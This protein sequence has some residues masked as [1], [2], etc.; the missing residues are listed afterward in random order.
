MGRVAANRAIVDPCRFN[1]NHHLDAQA[2][3]NYNQ[4][5]MKIHTALTLVLACLLLA[6]APAFAHAA[7]SAPPKAATAETGADRIGNSVVQVFATRRDPDF[8]KPWTKQSPH[9]M[10]GSGV[11][12]D[13]KRILTNAHVVNYASQIQVQANHAGDKVS[14]T[15]VAIAPDIDLALLKLDDESFFSSRPAVAR[16]DNLPVVKDAVMVYGFPTG[17]SSLSITKGIVSRIEFVSYSSS[18]SGLRIQIDAAINHGNSGGPV[19]AD[20]KM[21]G[22]VFSQ[23]GGAQNI[24]YIIPCEEI[25]LFL[26]DIADGKYDGKPTMFDELQTLENPALRAFLKLDKSTEGIVVHK[27]YG[28]GADYPLK[29]WDLITRIGANKID[30]QGM[31]QLGDNLRIRFQYLIQ[32]L[33]K[34]GKVQMTVVRAGKEISLQLPVPTSRPM[35]LPDLS[36]KYPS[37]FIYGPLVFS[38]ASMQLVSAVSGF[39][40]GA[41]IGTPLLSR[42]LDPPAFAG[43]EIVVVS[44]PF[45]PHKL[46]SGYSSPM[47]HVLSAV[48][49]V[50]IKN[51]RH[52]VQVLRDCRDPFIAVEFAGYQ[53]EDL[54]FARAEILAATEDILT[55]NGIR[56]QG[57]PDTLEVWRG[58]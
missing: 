37:Y 8:T 19:I 33:T 1:R 2:H 5:R 22:L 4:S 52:L 55:D 27:P 54:V 41:F 50:P 45:L 44:S 12:I 28:K 42:F 34:N 48:N 18:Q 24:G 14:A 58:K 56:N 40:H 29:K 30:D 32:K 11:I 38:S 31:V 46:A 57:S 47:G 7:A 36:G 3:A 35:L 13:G 20:D 16:A 9:E 21:I 15:V 49:R 25:E 26:S 6:L 51:L 43:E 17:G 53:G 23:L 10:T 39:G